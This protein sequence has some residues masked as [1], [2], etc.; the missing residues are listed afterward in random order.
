[1]A[2]FDEIGV[3]SLGDLDIAKARA[4]L[5]KAKAEAEKRFS[6]IKAYDSPKQPDKPKQPPA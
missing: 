2:N 1:M 5:G 3:Y 6:K 4:D